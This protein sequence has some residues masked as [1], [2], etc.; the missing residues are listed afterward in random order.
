MAS[1]RPPSRAS[2]S[3]FVQTLCP[4][5]Q[6]NIAL[7]VGEEGARLHV[8]SEHGG[9]VL[10]VSTQKKCPSCEAG[11]G[12]SYGANGL[13][14]KLVHEPYHRRWSARGLEWSPNGLDLAVASVEGHGITMLRRNGL[15]MVRTAEL[16]RC[17]HYGFDTSGERLLVDFTPFPRRSDSDRRLA[18]W[19]PTSG[20]LEPLENSPIAVRTPMLRRS[21]SSP[22]AIGWYRDGTHVIAVSSPKTDEVYVTAWTTDGSAVRS[23]RIAGLESGRAWLEPMGDRVLWEQHVGDRCVLILSKIDPKTSSIVSSPLGTREP[24]EPM[25]VCDVVWEPDGSLLVAYFQNEKGLMSYERM[26]FGVVRYDGELRVRTR[27]FPL[28]PELCPPPTDSPDSPCANLFEPPRGD[29]VFVTDRAYTL[30]FED[31]HPKSRLPTNMKG[32]QA[33]RFD[34]TGEVVAIA[35]PSDIHVASLSSKDRTSLVTTLG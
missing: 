9:H 16:A 30:D 26:P 3:G 31:L 25:D 24:N 22:D 32:A 2:S 14:V 15:T 12:V 6:Q 29:V 8:A 33:F 17:E 34:P 20:D 21:R 4:H 18:S 7:D 10:G 19:S 11:L 1:V 5:C 23:E 35:G 27:R 13:E 28:D